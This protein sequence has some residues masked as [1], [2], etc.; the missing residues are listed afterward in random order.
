MYVYVCLYTCRSSILVEL[1]F[2]DAGL[3]GTKIGEP[4][5]KKPLSKARTNKMAKGRSRAQA[6]SVGGERS[7]TALSLLPK[8]CFEKV[9][10]VEISTRNSLRYNQQV[11][12]KNK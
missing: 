7:H 9:D 11:D 2:G 6:T 1:E 8:L 4:E 3:W 12:K 5:K 10:E